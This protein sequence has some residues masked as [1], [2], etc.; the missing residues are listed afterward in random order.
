MS[1]SI[2]TVKPTEDAT[3]AQAPADQQLRA[4]AMTCRPALA[5][6]AS[7]VRSRTVRAA[8]RSCLRHELARHPPRVKSTTIRHG[9]HVARH[10]AELRRQPSPASSALAPS[11]S[12]RATCARLPRVVIAPQAGGA[13]RCRRRRRVLRAV[14]GMLSPRPAFSCIRPRLA[15]ARAARMSTSCGASA[16]FLEFVLLEIAARRSART[17]ARSPE[18][19]PEHRAARCTSRAC[20]PSP[21]LTG[22]ISSSR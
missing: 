7:S 19:P 21:T 20:A 12:G 22:S 11:P 13:A 5:W 6:S 18:Q 17:A 1:M 14:D 10:A 15:G 4:R 2:I 16:A 3:A 8:L 9:S